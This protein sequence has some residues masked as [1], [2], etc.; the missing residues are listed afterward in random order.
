MDQMNIPISTRSRVYGVSSAVSSLSLEGVREVVREGDEQ[1]GGE[2]EE[3]HTEHRSKWA[4][5]I[6]GKCYLT[7]KDKNGVTHR[8]YKFKQTTGKSGKVYQMGRRCFM[9][10]CENQSVYFCDICGPRCHKEVNSYFVDHL[11]MIKKRRGRLK[12]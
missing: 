3:D 11:N 12:N 7:L 9:E 10:G 4:H 8:M 5:L 1:E 6:D 2:D